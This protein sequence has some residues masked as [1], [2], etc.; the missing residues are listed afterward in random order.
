M[1]LDECG[2]CFDEGAVVKAV[3]GVV[4]GGEGGSLCGCQWWTGGR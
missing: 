4:I 1:V 2:G 3:I